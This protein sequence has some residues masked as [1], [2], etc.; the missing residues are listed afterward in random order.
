MPNISPFQKNNK[1]LMLALDQRGSFRRL[2][3]PENTLDIEEDEAIEAKKEIIRHLIQLPSGILLDTQYGL[4]AYMELDLPEPKPFLLAAEKTG[5]KESG[6]E[7]VTEILHTAEELRDYG[8]AGVKLLVY[9]NKDA[10]TSLDQIQTSKEVLDDAH[11]VNLPL[12][13]EIVHYQQE[14]NVPETVQTFLDA[15]VKPDVFKLEY[16]GSAE[17]CKAVTELLQKHKIPWII[18]TAGVD[19]D[20]FEERLEV[21]IGNGCNGF[22]AGRAIWKDWFLLEDPKEKEKFLKEEMAQRF[23]KI[24]DIALAG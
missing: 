24:C 6:D 21:A 18:L 23:Q 5:Y 1:I 17:E 15:G 19:Y 20:V 16:P 11:S 7:R 8:A 22:L 13:L 3:N 14:P 2:L 12:F 9:Y 10:R 4:P